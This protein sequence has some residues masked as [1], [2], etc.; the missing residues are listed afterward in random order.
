MFVPN[1]AVNSAS[2]CCVK[3]SDR[4][5]VVSNYFLQCVCEFAES[6]WSNEAYGYLD[7]N[8]TSLQ[9]YTVT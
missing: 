6:E 8:P 3:L 4:S 9:F 5:I 7:T 2:N 1:L